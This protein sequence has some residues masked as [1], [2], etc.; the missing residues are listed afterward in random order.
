MLI[1]ADTFPALLLVS[2]N[3]PTPPPKV[4]DRLKNGNVWENSGKRKKGRRV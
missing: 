2:W 3:I 1:T 4:S